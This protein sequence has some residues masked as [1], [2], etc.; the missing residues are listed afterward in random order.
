MSRKP[1]DEEKRKLIVELHKQG[2]TQ[3][4]IGIKIGI[5][6]PWVSRLLYAEGIKSRPRMIGKDLEKEFVNL[7]KDGKT[8]KEITDLYGFSTNAVRIHLKESGIKML[9]GK[10]D[11]KEIALMIRL[12][13]E[14][15][16]ALTIAKEIKRDRRTVR[17]YLAERGNNNVDEI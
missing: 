5:T 10:P 11:K 16:D 3:K 9:K 7:Y 6:Q 15:K 17:K 13:G 14:G 4:E 8:L 2:L 12:Q 1:L